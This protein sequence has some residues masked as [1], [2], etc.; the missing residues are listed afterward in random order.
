M[1]HMIKLLNLP[2]APLS[3]SYQVFRYNNGK[4]FTISCAS[5]NPKRGASNTTVLS[6]RPLYA[7]DCSSPNPLFPHVI[8]ISAT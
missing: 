4:T 8:S 2:T 7:T 3:R 6:Q 1:K 5:R